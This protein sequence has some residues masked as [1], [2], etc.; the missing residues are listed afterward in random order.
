MGGTLSQVAGADDGGGAQIAHRS[1]ERGQRTAIL[2]AEMH[3]ADM[4]QAVGRAAH[5]I[6]PDIS[7]TAALAL[8]RV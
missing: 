2:D 6:F 4:Q 1:L 8:S 5:P 3:V 7:A